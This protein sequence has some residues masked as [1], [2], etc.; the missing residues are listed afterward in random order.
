MTAQ[1]GEL[2]GG[3]PYQQFGYTLAVGKVKAAGMDREALIVGSPSYSSGDRAEIG[4]VSVYDAAS[5]ELIASIEGEQEFGRFGF[6]LSVDADGQILVGCP[7]CDSGGIEEGGSLYIYP[8]VMETE[9]VEVIG[10]TSRMAHMGYSVDSTENHV[11]VSEPRADSGTRASGSI[12]VRSHS[13]E[14]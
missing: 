9:I 4:M 3:S 7:R 13:L 1:I 5:L 11:V 10:S 14:M 12:L 6:A 8:D 2:R